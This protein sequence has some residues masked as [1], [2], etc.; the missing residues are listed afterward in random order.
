MPQLK[1]EFTLQKMVEETEKVLKEPIKEI[2]ADSG[3]SSYENYEYLSKNNKTGYIPD[4]NF[5]KIKT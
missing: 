1:Q 5:A 4:Q 3:Y 2:A